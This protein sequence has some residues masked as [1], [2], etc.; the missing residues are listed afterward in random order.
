MLPV[1]LVGQTPSAGIDVTAWHI[2][3]NAGTVD[4]VNF[5][6]TTDDIPFTIKV[7]GQRSG[8]IDNKHWF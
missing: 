3:G 2:T 5:L 7:N 6:G 4:G 8:R 1:W